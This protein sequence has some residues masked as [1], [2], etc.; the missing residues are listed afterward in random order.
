MGNFWCAVSAKR[1]K[2]RNSGK[3]QFEC[4]DTGNITKVLQYK[5]WVGIEIGRPCEGWWGGAPYNRCKGGSGST[6]VDDTTA[7]DDI[8]SRRKFQ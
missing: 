3:E 1:E 8:Y 6:L 4:M 7:D 5:P 2:C